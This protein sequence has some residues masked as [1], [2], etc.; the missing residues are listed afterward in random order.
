MSLRRTLSLSGLLVVAACSHTPSAYRTEATMSV[1]ER[2]LVDVIERQLIAYNAHDAATFADTYAVDTR[3]YNFPDQP[4]LAGRDSV[5]S[6][7]AQFFA[8]APRVHAVAARRIVQGHLVI[9]HEVVAGIPG[10]DTVRAV[11]IYEVS[12][13]KISRAWIAR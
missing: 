5:R 13:G 8:A 7:Y 12:Q 6:A 1:T 10:A 4:Y 9:D 11:V 3:I 2:D